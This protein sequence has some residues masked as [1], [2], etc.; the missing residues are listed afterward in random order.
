MIAKA[1]LLDDIGQSEDDEEYIEYMQTLLMVINRAQQLWLEEA[2]WQ[3]SIEVIVKKYFK[4]FIAAGLHNPGPRL[5]QVIK[6]FFF[7]FSRT[8]TTFNIP[9]LSDNEENKDSSESSD[10]EEEVDDKMPTDA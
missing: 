10:I 9:S 8:K 3:K 7:F 6:S 4:L 2:H 1:T 5:L